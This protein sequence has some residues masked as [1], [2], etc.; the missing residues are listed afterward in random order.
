MI[1][2]TDERLRIACER[3]ALDPLGIIE[4]ELPEDMGIALKNSRM[5]EEPGLDAER[6]HDFVVS[7]EWVPE[8]GPLG[9][10]VGHPSPGWA[11]LRGLVDHVAVALEADRFQGADPDTIDEFFKEQAHLRAML[12]TWGDALVILADLEINGNG[13]DTDEYIASSMQTRVKLT[14]VAFDLLAYAGF[15]VCREIF[16]DRGQS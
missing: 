3:L 7:G 5:G 6:C 14:D 13:V 16:T 4:A 9:F 2:I 10:A 1:T 8:P 15:L 12:L 11:W